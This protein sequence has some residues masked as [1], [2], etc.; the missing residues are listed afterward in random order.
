VLRVPVLIGDGPYGELGVWLD[1]ADRPVAGDESAALVQLCELAGTALENHRLR[2][3]TQN[4]ATAAREG[5]RARLARDLHDELG[6]SLTSLLLGI[7]VAE[8]SLDGEPGAADVDALR[9]QFSKLRGMAGEAVEQV[10]RFAFE[11][12][13]SVLDDRGLVAALTALTSRTAAVTGLEITLATREF[14]D[15]RRLAPEVETAVYRVAQEALTNISRH[16]HAANA[17]VVLATVGERVRLV[18]D[19]DGVGADLASST[20][21]GS[22]LPGMSERAEQL[23][24]ELRIDAVPGEGTTLV[25]EIPVD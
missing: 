13:P 20:R 1:D 14:D 5:E 2:R 12:R 19:D 18:V 17:S 11:L 4:E 6:Q 15:G 16:A 23:G 24:G 3:A 25:L 22:G 8:Q 7:R 9:W 10:Q 21:R